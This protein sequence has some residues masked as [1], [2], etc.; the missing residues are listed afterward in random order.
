MKTI[1]N[2]SKSRIFIS[3]PNSDLQYNDKLLKSDIHNKN[4]RIIIENINNDYCS[5]NLDPSKQNM[6]YTFRKK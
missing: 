3:N 1:R 6:I 4:G 5:T 2:F